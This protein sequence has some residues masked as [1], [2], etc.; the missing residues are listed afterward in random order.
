MPTIVRRDLERQFWGQ[1]GT[2]VSPREAG[3]LVGVSKWV[4]QRWLAESGGV[5]PRLVEP[6]GRLRF[7]ERCQ[8]EAMRAAGLSVRKIASRL[9]RSPS[10]ISREVGRNG[11]ARA[12]GYG[13]RH[14][15]SQAD[16]RARR[17]KPT[18]LASSPVLREQVQNRLREEHSPQQIAHRLQLDFPDDVEMRVSEGVRWS[19]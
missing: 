8:I 12:R 4:V 2:S 16:R 11:L 18:K 19:V 15:Q 1:V 13:A 5:K 7:E 6:S 9:G 17:P 3:R 14:A 10:T